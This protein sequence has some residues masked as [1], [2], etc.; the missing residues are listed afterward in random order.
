MKRLYKP[1]KFYRLLGDLM[2]SAGATR[3]LAENERISKDFQ[4]RIMMAVTEVNGCR[5]CS[6]FHSRV[7]LMAG[8]DKK[9]IQQ[10][11]AGNFQDAPQNQLAA[12][13]FAQYYAESGGLPSGEAINC[14]LAEYGEA[15]TGAIL[16]YIRAIM[17]G[18]AWGN[19]LDALRKR[20]RGT[21]CENLTFGDELAVIFGPFVMIP[22]IFIEKLY[23]KLMIKQ[24]DL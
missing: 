15:K 16:A 14:M 10:T 4:E 12:L 23:S 3:R 19:M 6:Y 18:N 17:V 24:K 21:P 22:L 5:Y 9:E 1:K 11:L 2:S 20:L 13:Y 7:A 8:I